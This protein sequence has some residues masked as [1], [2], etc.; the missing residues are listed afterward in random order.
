[1][2]LEKKLVDWLQIQVRK[3]NTKGLVVGMSGG[4]DSSVVA[5]FAKKSFPDNMLGLIMPCFS[6][7]R[8]KEYALLVAK[9]F[10]IPTKI[11]P[12]TTVFIDLF[13]RLEGRSYIEGENGLAVSNIKPRLRMICLYYFANKLNYLVVGTG[14]KS[15]LTMGYFT[16]YGDGGVDILPLGG[17]L[18]TEI[19]QLARELGI[20][21][22]IIERVPTAGLWRGQTD[23]KEMGITYRELDRMIQ[24]IEKAEIKNSDVTV[25]EKI[26]EKIEISSHKRNIPHIFCPGEKM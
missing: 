26:K 1:M 5:V 7:E 21:D 14:N 25:A 12:L 13:N 6:N 11:I 22:E 4:V 24:A 10:D 8:D 18:K 15:E 20:P 17:M 9:K 23:E 3:T 2:N 16:K 19:W